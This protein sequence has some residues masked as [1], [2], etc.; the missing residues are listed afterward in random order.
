MRRL[1]R[2]LFNAV[3]V[4]SLVVCVEALVLCLRSY[5]REEGFSYQAVHWSTGV[6]STNGALSLD[7][8]HFGTLTQER[9][10][11]SWSYRVS[12]DTILWE[13]RQFEMEHRSFSVPKLG[14]ADRFTCTVPHWLVAMLPIGPLAVVALRRRFRERRISRSRCVVCNYD[15]RA[16]PDRC[17]ECGAIPAKEGGSYFNNA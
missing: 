1:L 16:T 17:P 3:I 4:L 6:R 15:L 14:G 5:G 10:W 12:S 7:Y 13:T 9:R 2:I 8:V 11:S